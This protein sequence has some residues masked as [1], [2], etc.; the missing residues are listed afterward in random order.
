[1]F[2]LPSIQIRQEYAQ[3]GIDADLG[4]YEMR[5]PRPTMEMQQTSTKLEM[6]QPNGELEIDQSKA[7]DALGLPGT[8][9]VMNRIYSQSRDIA[10][11]GIARRV[12][13]GNRMYAIHKGG[14][15]IADIAV[16]RSQISGFS[17]LDFVGEAAYDNVDIHFNRRAPEIQAERGGVQIN[18][19]VNRPEIEYHR[20]KLEYSMLRWG[21]VEITPPQIDTLM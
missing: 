15:P 5:Q 14:N 12:E 17:E 16:E 11:Q 6:H 1:M 18:T 7:W 13:D 4:Q 20:G 9:E 8:L 19:Q 3:I 10:L 21:K 2:P